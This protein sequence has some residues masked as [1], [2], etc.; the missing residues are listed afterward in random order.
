ME[1]IFHIQYWSYFKFSILILFETSHLI[2]SA[3]NVIWGLKERLC[4]SRAFIDF[5]A[6]FALRTVLRFKTFL[7]VLP[8]PWTSRRHFGGWRFNEKLRTTGTA[9]LTTHTS[10][11]DDTK[12][13]LQYLP[14]KI[15]SCNEVHMIHVTCLI[16]KLMEVKMW[17]ILH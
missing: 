13:L 15:E 8:Y 4:S 11:W 16:E 9:L 6:N 12:I 14:I 1:I 3:G 5:T 2:L 17:T 10:R 7:K